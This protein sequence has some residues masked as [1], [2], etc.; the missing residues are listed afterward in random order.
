MHRI[1]AIDPGDEH[2]GMAYFREGKCQWV[3]ETDP[4]ECEEVT[5]SHLD[6]GLEA[7]VVEAFRLYPEQAKTQIWSDFPTVQLIGVL[8]YL[9]R[10]SVAAGGTSVLA[11][12]GADIKKPTRRIL[13]A[14]KIR[15][16]AKQNK[17]GGHA[18][19]AELHGHHYWLKRA[20]QESE[21]VAEQAAGKRDPL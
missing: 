7:L 9:H 15:S 17:A 20:S 3:A 4:H 14:K 16:V 8:K 21:Y 19:D 18:A 5:K 12:Q 13:R 2:C 1:L 10:Q 11:V 6:E